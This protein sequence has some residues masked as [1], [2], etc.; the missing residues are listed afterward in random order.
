VIRSILKDEP[1]R[2]GL[3]KLDPEKALVPDAYNR[4]TAKMLDGYTALYHDHYLQVY[5]ENVDLK[6]KKMAYYEKRGFSVNAEKNRY[7]NE[8]LSDLVRNVSV[9]KR[10]VEYKGKIIQEINP[11]FQEPH[12]SGLLDYRAPFFAPEK[13]L[14]GITVN[15]Y[16]FNIFVIWFMAVFCYIALY[17]EW[18]KKVVNSF[19]KVNIPRLR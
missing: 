18:L 5:N 8:S 9:K 1:F 3:E 15:S 10:W 7:Y 13:N 4:A 2:T 16:F 12:P 6:D 14:A 11:I 19:G 17:F